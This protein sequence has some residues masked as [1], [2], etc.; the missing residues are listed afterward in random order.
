MTFQAVRTPVVKGLFWFQGERDAVIGSAAVNIYDVNFENLMFRFRDLLGADLDLTGDGQ[1]TD[2][3]PEFL[4]ENLVQTSNGLTGSFLGDLNCDG[5][6]NVLG[7][8]F[9]LIA[10]L[11]SAVS[12]Y[13][14]GDIDLNGVVNVL[15]DAFILISNLGRSNEL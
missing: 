13:S 2:R 1:I 5:T 4:I 14:D 3:D 15:G 10:N 7:D 9:V 8:A 11:N 12:S 6:V